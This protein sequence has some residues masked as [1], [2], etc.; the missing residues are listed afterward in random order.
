M[1][2]NECQTMDTIAIVTILVID[3]LTDCIVKT[4]CDEW[5]S[6]ANA[7]RHCEYKTRTNRCVN[8]VVWESY[9]LPIVSLG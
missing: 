4:I 1:P 6:V 5:D 3:N 2:T 9:E 7:R 8:Y